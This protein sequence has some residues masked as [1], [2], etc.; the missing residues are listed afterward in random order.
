MN[1]NPNNGGYEA[2]NEA[3]DFESTPAKSNGGGQVFA[4]IS[5]IT[6]ILPFVGMNL[7]GV[8]NIAAIVFA[9]IA[10]KQ[11]SKSPMATIGLILGIILDP[12]IFS[13]L[14]PESDILLLTSS[15]AM[16]LYLQPDGQKVF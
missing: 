9:I 6:G 5:L 3:I 14:F 1:N 12:R 2:S 4:I 16:D 7:F 10:K 11:G 15:R 8:C 13:V